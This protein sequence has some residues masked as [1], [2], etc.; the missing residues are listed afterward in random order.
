MKVGDLESDQFRLR[1]RSEFRKYFHCYL[2]VVNQRLPT[3]AI[4]VLNSMDALHLYLIIKHLVLA[5]LLF[6]AYLAKKAH[7]VVKLLVLG[8]SHVLHI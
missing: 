2:G 6:V 1:K 7:V 5:L 8:K 3:S 4:H